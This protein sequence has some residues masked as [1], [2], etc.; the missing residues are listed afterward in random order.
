MPPEPLLTEEDTREL[1]GLV[2]ETAMVP[3][4][5]VAKRKFLISGLAELVGADVW[6]SV[7]SEWS[8]D[9]GPP[10]PLSL[11]HGG[12]SDNELAIV[13][14]ANN[15]AEHPPAENA[16]WNEAVLNADTT[17][18]R[19]RRQLIPDDRAWYRNANTR[20]YREGFLDDFIFS[21]QPLPD[22][23]VATF[24]GIGLHRRW[25]REPFTAREAR[26]AHIVISEVQWLHQLSVDA[27]PETASV[28]GL[29]P[30]M[31]SVLRYLLDGWTQK[32]IAVQVGLS[33]HTVNGYV[34]D[35]YRHFNVHSRNELFKRFSE[36]DGGDLA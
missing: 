36:G 21:A 27:L 7:I 28:S 19:M 30:R 18:T 4:N 6:L 34:K 22:C 31:R 25:G 3:G 14:E 12:L 5:H 13:V 9:D 20:L 8:L 33:P 35:L 23:P 10:F 32:R 17:I 11:I 16:K 26:M 15:D 29:T 2:G 24:S 1:V